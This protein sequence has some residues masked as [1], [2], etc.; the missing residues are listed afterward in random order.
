MPI[1]HEV[2]ILGAGVSGLA[3]AERL[4]RASVDFLVLEAKPRIGGRVLT[5]YS[6][7]DGH[8][9][10]V[11]AFYIHGKRVVTHAWVRDA[12]L[13]TRRVPVLQRGRFWIDGRHARFPYLMLPFHPTFGLRAFY[14]AAYALP[15]AMERYRGPD[16]SLAEFLDRVDALPGARSLVTILRAHAAAAD[17]DEVGVRGPSEE[18]ALATESFGYSNYQILEGYSDL[19]ARRA[20]SLRDRIRLNTKVTRVER[21]SARVRIEALTPEGPE[22]FRAKRVVVTLPLGVLKADAVAFD[23]PLPDSKRRAIEAIAFGHAMSI[24]MRLREG[25][26]TR[27]LGD[28][29]LMWGG[30][31]STFHRP[32]VALRG[33]PEI[34]AAF[35]VGREADRRARLRDDEAI[36][37]TLEELHAILPAGTR[38]GILDAHL[39][40]RWSADPDVLGGYT[41]LPPHVGVRERRAL[42]EPVDGVLFFAGEATH[43]RGESATVH[44]AIE[45][46]Y[47]AAG[48]TLRS[49]RAEAA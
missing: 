49:L 39:V 24:Q 4:A 28:F 8:P 23:P 27:R 12:G 41:F 38:E 17:A 44:G 20:A 15:K 40:Q 6:L 33:R 25:N 11:G 10:E 36:A 32:F 47:R 3:C 13:R 18:D 14:Q 26:L 45:T 34:L 37:A 35:V 7:A 2:V 29:G 43:T 1:E 21:N 48:E 30:G 31:A 5:D 19:V 42:A 46:G 16:L 22:E 9:I